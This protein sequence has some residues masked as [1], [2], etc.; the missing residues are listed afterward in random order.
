MARRYHLNQ[1]YGL[2]SQLEPR[3]RV[4]P[5]AAG[6]IGTELK[7]EPPLPSELPSIL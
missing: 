3:R 2:L 6:E 4:Q 5:L 7:Q 1:G